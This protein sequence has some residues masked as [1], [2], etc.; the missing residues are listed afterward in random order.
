MLRG[1]G[2]NDTVKEPRSACPKGH[3][4][5]IEKKLYYY[6]SSIRHIRTIER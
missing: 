4:C 5:P 6:Y 3:H 1:M 2:W